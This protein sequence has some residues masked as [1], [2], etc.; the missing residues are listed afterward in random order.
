[1][2]RARG[3]HYTKPRSGISPANKQGSTSERI[4]KVLEEEIFLGKLS[5][6]ERIDEQREAA[7]F[8]VSRTPV[9]EALHFLA[10]ANLV[11]LQSR[12]GAVVTRLTVSQIIE[13]LEVH[14]HLEA[15]CAEQAALGG[16]AARRQL[17]AKIHESCA[18]LV[19]K[20]KID[21]YYRAAKTLHELIYEMVGNR[22]LAETCLALRNRI[23]PYLRYQLHSPGRAQACLGEQQGL[24]EA[25]IAR[26]GAAAYERARDHAMIQRRVFTEFVDALERTGLSRANFEWASSIGG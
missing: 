21:E 8:G 12:R 5:P 23:F 25:I 24:V 16:D 11:T 22:F 2:K 20:G 14:A 13:M 3:R 4:R 6:G 15:L 18:A 26:D 10:S 1:M 17:L 9:R 7:R 19:R